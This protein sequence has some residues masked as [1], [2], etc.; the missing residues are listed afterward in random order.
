MAG[1]IKPNVPVIYDA[2]DK[3]A[4]GVI[5]EKAECLGAP[6]F[7]VCGE[8]TRYAADLPHMPGKDRNEKAAHFTAP[9]QRSNAALALETIRVIGPERVT[10]ETVY[11]G[12]SSV[13]WQGRMEEI[14]H[15][16]WLDGAHNPG[17][18]GAFIK[19]VLSQ[20]DADGPFGIHLLF[21]V[22]EDKD[23]RSMIHLLCEGLSPA[24][25]TV[26]AFEGER[27]ADADE[28]ALIFMEQGCRDVKAIRDPYEALKAA[29]AGRKS[30]EDRLYIIGSLYLIGALRP[31][32]IK[33]EPLKK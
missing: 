7:P 31:R 32:L 17:G 4:A 33:P 14:R 26:T 5:A 30:E 16:I 8:D 12:L 29:L 21:A 18:I 15:G 28:L 20:E 9:Y 11:R 19:A 27:A 10:C 1:I 23:Y 13:R 6:A 25:V 24:A 22:A 3:E 2:S